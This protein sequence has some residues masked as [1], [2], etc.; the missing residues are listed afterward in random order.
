VYT[1]H[2]GDDDDDDDD[3]NN[4][5]HH[6]HQTLSSRPEFFPVSGLF[7]AILPL[8]IFSPTVGNS[9]YQKC[10]IFVTWTNPGHLAPRIEF[11]GTEPCEKHQTAAVRVK[12]G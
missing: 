7:I 1:L 9:K 11:R 5:H 6:H 12:V 8:Q 10:R 4:H 3:D 2:K